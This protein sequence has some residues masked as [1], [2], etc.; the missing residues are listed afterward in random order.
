MDAKIMRK[1]NA[2]ETTV[3]RKST[4]NECNECLSKTMEW[5]GLIDLKESLG[6]NKITFGDEENNENSYIRMSKRY[7]KERLKEHMTDLKFQHNNTALNI[8]NSENPT[9]LKTIL[10][11]TA[12]IIQ[13]TMNLLKYL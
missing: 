4:N 11:A 5:E 7:T 13:W 9:Q 2:I 6:I 10:H 1:S 8:I 12:I 3:Y